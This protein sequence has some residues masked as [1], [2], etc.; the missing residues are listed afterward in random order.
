MY[1]MKCVYIA[2]RNNL[3]LLLLDKV[4][5]EVTHEPK[6]V[7]AANFSPAGIRG[8]KWN[9]GNRTWAIRAITSFRFEIT[10]QSIHDTSIRIKKTALSIGLKAA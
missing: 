6:I 4:S 7:I 5:Q 2:V 1:T 10:K 3:I 8:V 9:G